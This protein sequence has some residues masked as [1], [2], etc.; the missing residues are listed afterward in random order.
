MRLCMS[1]LDYSA[2]PIALRE[3]LSFTKNGVVDM[4]RSIAREEGLLGVVLLSTCNRT[5]LYLSY[6][7]GPAPDPGELLC[8][9]AGLPEDHIL[10]AR[11]PFSLADNLETMERYAIRSLVTKDGGAAGGFPEKLEAARRL[12]V[13][14]LLIRRPAEA[15]L[16]M[17][18]LRTRLEALVWSE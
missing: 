15:G 9:A 3:Q 6:A 18:E 10:A 5:E 8:R 16:T 1:G 11:G 17:A 14:V 7:D 13:Q 4:D 2:A 12:G